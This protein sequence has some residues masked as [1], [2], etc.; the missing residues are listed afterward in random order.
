[1]S[2]QPARHAWLFVD[3][4]VLA[5]AVATLALLWRLWKHK[6]RIDDITSV[7]F[8]KGEDLLENLTTFSE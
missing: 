2:E 7:A 5:V 8:T 3:V 1:V 4:L 6:D